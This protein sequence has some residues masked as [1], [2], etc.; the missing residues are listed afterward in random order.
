MIVGGVTLCSLG[1]LAL[2]VSLL[3][4]VT[5]Y[6]TWTP[7][8]LLDMAFPFLFGAY[9]LATMTISCIAIFVGVSLIAGT[10]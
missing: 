6:K 2:A 8:S 4:F 7:G 9:G 5:A 3:M 10:P 1:V